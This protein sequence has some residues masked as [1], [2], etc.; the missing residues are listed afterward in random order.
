MVDCITEGMKTDARSPGT[1]IHIPGRCSEINDGGGDKCKGN[2]QTY[3]YRGQIHTH[4]TTDR[5]DST[6]KRNT[7]NNA[8]TSYYARKRPEVQ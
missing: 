8:N 2:A 4:H 1:G 6:T 5:N 3:E 7:D